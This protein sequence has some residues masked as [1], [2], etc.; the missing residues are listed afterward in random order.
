VLG[1]S[2]FL[3]LDGLPSD[4]DRWDFDS[5]ARVNVWV[6]MAAARLVRGEHTALHMFYCEAADVVRLS[7]W[8]LERSVW[9]EEIPVP[10]DFGRDVIRA[11]RRSIRRVRRDR[12]LIS[13]T[14]PYRWH[15]N[16]RRWHAT[17]L[18]ECDVRLFSTEDIPA[19]LPYAVVNHH[20][21]EESKRG[22]A[23]SD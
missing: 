10:G 13:G 19:V 11:L 22:A 5:P 21:W 8:E 12:F 2:I 18:H 4:W 6:R 15:G 7:L 16:V 1:N 20:V 17:S 23:A 14:I 9:V 3:D